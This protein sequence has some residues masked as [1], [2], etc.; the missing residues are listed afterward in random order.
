MAQD[1][2]ERKLTAILSADVVAFSRLMRHDEARTAQ[3]LKAHRDL[4]ATQVRQHDGWVVDAVGNNLLAE[5]P[6]ALDAVRCAASIQR[7]LARREAALPE[8][9]RM[10]FRIGVVGDGVNIAARI[11]GLAQRGGVS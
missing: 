10:R 1:K 3:A 6:D 7:E 8:D 9:Q 2:V 11:E 5:F 4:I